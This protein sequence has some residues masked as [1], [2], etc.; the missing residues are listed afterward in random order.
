MMKKEWLEFGPSSTKSTT[1]LHT[2]AHTSAYMA[3]LVSNTNADARI[4]R[5]STRN[6]PTL[7]RRD[8]ISRCKRLASISVPPVVALPRRINP[9]PRPHNRPPYSEESHRSSVKRTSATLSNSSES[10]T[11]AISERRPN[12]SPSD[13][14]EIANSGTFRHSDTTPTGQPVAE[15]I[16]CARPVN[17]PAAMLFGIRNRL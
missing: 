17:P 12:R 4:T 9:K 10:P 7:T 14:I 2:M 3:A 8:G 15:L 1:R 13:F 11:V 6:M 5:P 16:N